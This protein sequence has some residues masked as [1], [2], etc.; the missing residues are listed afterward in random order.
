MCVPCHG[1]T[2][3]RRVK[4][5]GPDPTANTKLAEVLKV[6]KDANVPKDIV[7]R[8]IKKASDSKQGDYQEVNYEC[9]GPGGTG[10]VVE[11]LTDNL[12]RCARWRPWQG[13]ASAPQVSAGVK[14]QGLKRSPAV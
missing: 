5:G 10:F 12:N 6:A 8:N 1:T 2:G 14:G 4:A 11:C 7:E 9:Y 13:D 3:P